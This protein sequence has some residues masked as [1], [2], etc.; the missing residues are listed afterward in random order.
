MFDALYSPVVISGIQ[1]RA[2]FVVRFGADTEV[3]A[4]VYQGRIEH[5]FSGESM[6]FSSLDELLGFMERMLSKINAEDQMV[7]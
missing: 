3:A 6:H 1:H 5:V 2:A 7:E 4:H